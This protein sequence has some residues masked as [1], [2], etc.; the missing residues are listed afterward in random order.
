MIAAPDIDLEFRV[1]SAQSLPPCRV[2]YAAVDNED[3]DIVSGAGYASDG[4]CRGT[5]DGVPH[6]LPGKVRTHAIEQRHGA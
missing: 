1:V 4:Q 5:D 2:E 6:V 3:I